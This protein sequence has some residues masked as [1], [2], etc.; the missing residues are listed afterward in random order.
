MS[1]LIFGAKLLWCMYC[2][3]IAIA[4]RAGRPLI[5]LA[6]G[7]RA[8]NNESAMDAYCVTKP[9][10]G[11]NTNW[12]INHNA[13]C[14]LRCERHR[15]LLRMKTS[16]IAHKIILYFN[17]RNVFDMYFRSLKAHY[18]M[19]IGFN[20]SKLHCNSPAITLY[21]TL[22]TDKLKIRVR[23]RRSNYCIR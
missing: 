8:G 9:R 5:A 2:N 18:W 11:R 15:T 20:R 12:I 19:K 6:W 22:R 23:S 21:K 4:Y 14:P 17:W 1:R 3:S 13:H 10:F 7:G 16:E